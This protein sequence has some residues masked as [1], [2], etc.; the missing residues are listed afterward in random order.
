M[1]AGLGLCALPRQ[2]APPGENL[3]IL[4]ALYVFAVI[5]GVACN[6]FFPG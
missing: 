3:C 4:G 1:G 6:L 2:Q 5:T